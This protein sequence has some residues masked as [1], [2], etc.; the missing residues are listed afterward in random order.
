[1][2]FSSS[3]QWC[4]TWGS[5]LISIYNLICCLI[6]AQNKNKCEY[7][8]KTEISLF[9]TEHYLWLWCF[10]LMGTTAETLVAN[11]SGGIAHATRQE[12]DAATTLFVCVFPGDITATFHIKLKSPLWWA[13]LYDSKFCNVNSCKHQGDAFQWWMIIYPRSRSLSSSITHTA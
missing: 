9:G 4:P 11:D 8:R 7:F 6:W 3:V 1:M 5:G 13:I 12:G 2:K 10:I